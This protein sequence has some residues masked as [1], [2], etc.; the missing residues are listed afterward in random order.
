M[1]GQ[2][3]TEHDIVYWHWYWHWY[4]LFAFGSGN[5]IARRYLQQRGIYMSNLTRN[6]NVHNSSTP[7]VS[8]LSWNWTHGLA[9]FSKIHVGARRNENPHL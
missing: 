7:A 4:R 8:A 3:R 5:D 2:D 1:T 9:S 6:H